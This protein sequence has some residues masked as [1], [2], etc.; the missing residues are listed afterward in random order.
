[1]G[2]SGYGKHT[3]F[4]FWPYQVALLFNCRVGVCGVDPAAFL[5]NSRVDV[6]RDDPV[7]IL[8]NSRVDVC[9]ANPVALLSNCRVGVVGADPV[10]RLL[11]T[12]TGNVNRGQHSHL[13][14]PTLFSKK[15]HIWGIDRKNI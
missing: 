6:C 11:N 9:P 10:H 15:C 14:I 7:D 2:R 13:K 12:R 5:S 8:S 1:M 4:L 3:Y